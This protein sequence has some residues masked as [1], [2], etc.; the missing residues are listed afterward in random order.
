M[1]LL[2]ML[3]STVSDNSFHDRGAV[4]P[5]YS[6]YE[7]LIQAAE[8]RHGKK[9]TWDKIREI[10][11]NTQEPYLPTYAGWRRDPETHDQ[12]F[13]IITDTILNEEFNNEVRTYAYNEIGMFQD[14]D[15]EKELKLMK[16]LFNKVN[17]ESLK[18]D[19]SLDILHG[20]IPMEISQPR[21]DIVLRI[22]CFLGDESE[23]RMTKYAKKYGKERTLELLRY[24]LNSK[25]I[26]NN[27]RN[28]IKKMIKVI[29]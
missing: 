29:T 18:S 7:L 3:E 12:R 27:S 15:D 2:N 25:Y 9:E 14:E 4:E 23:L 28:F 11:S 6:Q 5:G 20:N 10:I 1:N 8:R 13:Q 22:I 17:D 21:S 24:A 26:T 16:K 19:I